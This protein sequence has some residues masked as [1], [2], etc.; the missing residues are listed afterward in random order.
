MKQSLSLSTDGVRIVVGRHTPVQ[1]SV[2]WTKVVFEGEGGSGV[3]GSV[4]EDGRENV[5]QEKEIRGEKV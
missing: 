5:V 4:T 3:R 1:L 2:S